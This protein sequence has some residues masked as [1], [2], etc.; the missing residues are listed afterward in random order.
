MRRRLG[1]L[2]STLALVTALGP[3][4]ACDPALD[5]G[6]FRHPVP[7]PEAAPP[8]AQW[9]ADLVGGLN[10]PPKCPKPTLAT[11]VVLDTDGQTR[12]VA[13]WLPDNLDVCYAVINHAG[14]TPTTVWFAAV[15]DLLPRTP[16]P[17]DTTAGVDSYAVTAYRGQV[18]EI[19]VSGDPDHLVSPVRRRTLDL[20]AGDLVTFAAYHYRIPPTGR[21]LTLTLCTPTGACR[22][23]H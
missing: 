14:V 7:L 17:T 6:T 1:A 5:P 16:M 8:S 9:I 11:M 2:C 3:A 19:T 22:D 4:T 18:G 23:S 20:G 15:A 10:L 21:P 13:L 12:A